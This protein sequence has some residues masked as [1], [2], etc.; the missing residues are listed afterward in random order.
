[1][2]LQ[3]RHSHSCSSITA[4]SAS[5]YFLLNMAASLTTCNRLLSLF[6]ALLS[7]PSLPPS[8]RKV[9]TVRRHP[10]ALSLVAPGQLAWTT[11]DS[12]HFPA[13]II[14]T[15]SAGT[16]PCR[17]GLRRL[18]LRFPLFLFSHSFAPSALPEP[19]ISS[20]SGL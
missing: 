12:A 14:P 16:G 15:C 10:S 4:V 1:M 8:R 3:T 5:L 2:S 20:R 13:L 6:T 11:W 17:S 19:F 7:P 18:C 9:L